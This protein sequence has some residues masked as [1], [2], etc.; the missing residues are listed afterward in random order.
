MFEEKT[1]RYRDTIEDLSS[2]KEELQRT[3]EL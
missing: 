2:E 1:Q 3:Y